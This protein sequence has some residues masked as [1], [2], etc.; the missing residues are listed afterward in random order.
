[1]KAAV[2]RMVISPQGYVILRGSTAV[3]EDRPSA[4]SFISRTRQSLIEAH[5]LKHRDD[6]LFEFSAD[7]PFDSPST[8]ASMIA[9]GNTNGRTKWRL[10]DGKTLKDIEEQSA[11]R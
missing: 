4:A 11:L 7:V 6:N 10:P 8:A 2:G 5:I 3:R 9:G 1:M